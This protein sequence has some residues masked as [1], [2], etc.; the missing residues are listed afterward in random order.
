M[1]REAVRVREA[2]TA[3]ERISEVAGHSAMLVEGISHSSND[4]VTAT[5]E[6]VRSMQRI[7]EVS[8]RT[9]EGAEQA[10]TLIRELSR[11]CAPFRGILD[12]HAAPGPQAQADRPLES[13][14]PPLHSHSSRSTRRHRRSQQTA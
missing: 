14:H 7:S 6:L 10:R 1:D 2:G 3:L 11:S 4:Q 12:D 9:L 5:Q 13:P 8:Q